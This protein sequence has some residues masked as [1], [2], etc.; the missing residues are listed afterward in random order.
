MKKENVA[1]YLKFPSIL[2][3][4]FLTLFP[5]FPIQHFFESLFVESFAHQY[6]LDF[7]LAAIFTLFNILGVASITYN[8]YKV[9]KTDLVSY[10]VWIL[11]SLLSF[12]FTY[13]GSLPQTIDTTYLLTTLII[14]YLLF[15]TT[16]YSLA[17]SFSAFAKLFQEEK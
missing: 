16:S 11:A 13:F 5:F 8:R 2:L 4:F 7:V 6:Y 9:N 3:A 17:D 10:L 12:V 15:L 1:T 14:L